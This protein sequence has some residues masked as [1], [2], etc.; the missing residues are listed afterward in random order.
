[1]GLVEMHVRILRG[2]LKFLFSHFAPAF[3]VHAVGVESGH[4]IS[5]VLEQGFE[6]VPRACLLMD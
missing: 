1:M 3:R 5:Q 2:L 6:C 4:M